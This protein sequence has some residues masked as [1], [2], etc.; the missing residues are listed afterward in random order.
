MCDTVWV[1][2]EGQFQEASNV[3]ELEALLG[4]K[5]RF[6]RIRRRESLRG[7]P[8]LCLCPVAMARTAKRAGM[9]FKRLVGG[10]ESE[11]FSL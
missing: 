2:R 7:Q 8:N 9:K 1:K 11:M 5:V 6:A 10:M 3:G 4:V